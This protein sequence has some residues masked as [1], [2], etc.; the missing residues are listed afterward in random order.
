[1]KIGSLVLTVLAALPSARAQAPDAP[2]VEAYVFAAPFARPDF[3]GWATYAAAGGEIFLH[4][5]ASIGVEVGPVIAHSESGGHY[6][7]GLGSANLAYHFSRQASVEPFV[8]AGY[9]ATFRA[10]VR[11]GSNVGAGINVWQGRTVAL[12]FEFRAYLGRLR[13]DEVGPRFGVAFR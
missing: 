1:M 13:V 5:G 11:N 7:F 9:S 2:R 3:G 10:G 6:V 8:T 4:R 12:R